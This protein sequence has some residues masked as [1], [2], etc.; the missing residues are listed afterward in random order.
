LVTLLVAAMLALLPA[1]AEA[2]TEDKSTP[3]VAVR[4]GESLW[5]ISEQRLGPNAT[6]QRIVEGAERI[7]ALNRARIGADPD[8]IFVGQELSLPPAMSAPPT[9]ATLSR[10]TAEAAEAGPRDRAA[11]GTKG[12]AQR[13]ASDGADVKGGEASGPVTEREAEP[14]TLPDVAAAA[15][16]PAVGAVASN[17]AQPPPFVSFSRTIRTEVVSAASALAE[18]FESFFGVSADAGTE[19]RRLLCLGVLALTLLVAAFLAWKLPMRRTTRGDAERWGMPAGYYGETPPAHRVAPFAYHP[20]SLGGSLGDRD[21]QGTRREAPR[22]PGRGRRAVLTGSGV[23]CAA[24]IIRKA[25]TDAVL[26]R[27]PKAVAVARNGLALG[28]HNPKVRRAPRRAH[29]TMRARKLRP[30]LRPRRGAPRRPR[31]PVTFGQTK[32][33]STRGG[34]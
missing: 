20:G 34:R 18:S 27:A 2:Q 3:S 17:D 11:K 14:A 29:A 22:A 31:P 30:R 13:T 8:L 21:E 19:G 15:P 9:G 12:E 16:V 6:P 5:S 10:K 33:V 1:A 25:D 23:P 7:Y 4:A 24:S 26:G 32:G 28:A